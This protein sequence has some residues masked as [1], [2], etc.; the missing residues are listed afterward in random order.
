MQLQN[1]RIFL[2]LNETMLLN[3]QN[4]GMMCTICIFN[5][6]FR[7]FVLYYFRLSLDRG[8]ER[9]TERE[10]PRQKETASVTERGRERVDAAYTSA[11][12]RS[13]SL[14]ASVCIY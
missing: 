14:F 1:Y 13:A 10:R 9:E 8:G 2:F 11:C 12:Y 4:S 5:V 3:H 7:F 6:T